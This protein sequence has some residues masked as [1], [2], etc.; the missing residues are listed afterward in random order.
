[1]EDGDARCSP[2]TD[3][4]TAQ[5]RHGGSDGV[6]LRRPATEEGA[7]ISLTELHK[8]AVT[9]DGVGSTARTR[10]RSIGALV[11]RH[12]LVSFFVLS[13]LLSWWAVVP[14]AMGLSPVP[15]AGFGPFLAALIVLALTEG[16]VG[17]RA[18][19][20][21]MVTWRVPVR[22]YVLAIGLPL[23]LSG[24]AIVADLALGAEMPSSSD[25]A[26]WSVIPVAAL[27]F[28]LVP[29]IGGAWEEPGWRGY[30]LP[31]LER[32]FGAVTGP[33]VLGVL[34]VVWHGPLFFAGQIIWTDVLVIVAASVVI[35]SV[36]H[37]A[38]ESVLVVMIMHA[39]NNAVGGGF[40]S[41]LFHGA[42]LTR[43]GL[44]TA[45]AWWSVAA[46][47]IIRTR[48]SSREIPHVLGGSPSRRSL[49][50]D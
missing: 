22:A 23:L 30:A 50:D 9:R 47:V 49:A 43:L 48:R 31:R 10:H 16:R 42:D 19:L 11:R 46:V 38:R 36:F 40:A 27:L 21:S 4:G 14:F 8:D 5:S 24:S 13:C 12:P 20:R 17:V 45:L 33:L 2:Q 28:L 44:L 1:V 32:I 26:A 6:D 41:Q 35:A 7:M 25:L 37:T 3:D 18:L 34:W 39:T 29:G 15:V